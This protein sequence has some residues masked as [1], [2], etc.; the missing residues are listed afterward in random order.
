MASQEPTTSSTPTSASKTETGENSCLCT[1]TSSRRAKNILLMS[2]TMHLWNQSPQSSLR[3]SNTSTNVRI[4][5]ELLFKL[6]L[7]LLS[8]TAALAIAACSV[9]TI[10]FVI[11]ARASLIFCFP[12]LLS[13]VLLMTPACSL[14]FTSWSSVT[15]FVWQSCCC[16]WARSWVWQCLWSE[17]ETCWAKITQSLLGLLCSC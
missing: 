13:A 12:L 2:A 9:K 6:N 14:A 7:T 5:S 3:C 4:T 8:L 17:S 11:L 16:S 1:M 10:A 15:V